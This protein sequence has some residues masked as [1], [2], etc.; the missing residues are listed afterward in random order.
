MKPTR[1]WWRDDLLVGVLLWVGACSAGA[2]EAAFSKLVKASLV[3]HDDFDAARRYPHLLKVFLRLENTHDA[4]ISWVGSGVSGIEAELLDAAN[5]PVPNPPCAASV[6]SGVSAYLLPF[7]SKLD[8]LI[9][10]GGISMMG[11]T[12]DK[13][14][15]VVGDRGWLIPVDAV[16]AYTLRVRLR[17]TPGRHPLKLPETFAAKLLLDLPPARVEVAP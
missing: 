14:A 1:R 13:Y 17:G 3:F 8:W 9:S 5:K 11:D 12:R 10:H 4:D 7:G 6:T 16:S 2:Q 15:L